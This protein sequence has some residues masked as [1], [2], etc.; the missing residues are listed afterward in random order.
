MTDGKML[1]KRLK[2]YVAQSQPIARRPAR[3]ESGTASGSLG[4]VA[5][6]QLHPTQITIGSREVLA[7]R[8]RYRAAI[9][10]GG[11]VLLQRHGVPI[12]L[13]PH[14]QAYAL[15]RHHGLCALLAEGVADVRVNLTEDLS[16]LS[17]EAFWSTLDA[18]GWCHPYDAS[19]QRL[20][21]D[22]IPASMANLVDDPYR[23]LASALRRI[24]GFKKVRAPFSEF[25]W[26]DFLRRRLDP[27]LVDRDFNE[28]LRIAAQ[29]ARGDGPHR[30]PGGHATA[31]RAT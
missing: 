20:D 3:R 16:S 7:K 22:Q 23:S 6:A 19:G 4:T 8:R 25:A 14:G 30:L 18:R 10:A 21:Y 11:A 2:N 5:I 26:A 31:G 1:D 13:G 28:A 12:V 29:M 9:E 15:D 17:R 27:A 24:G